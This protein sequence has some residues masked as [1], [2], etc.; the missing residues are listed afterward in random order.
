MTVQ[1]ANLHNKVKEQHIADL[2]HRST[3]IDKPPSSIKV[4]TSQSIKGGKG[5]YV[6]FQSNKDAERACDVL[7]GTKLKG[8]DI[9]IRCCDKTKTET[10]GKNKKK[11]KKT[12]REKEDDLVAAM[13][14]VSISPINLKK[15]KKTKQVKMKKKSGGNKGKNKLNGKK[16]KSKGFTAAKGAKKKK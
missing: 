9:W 10:G 13:M 7:N 16:K 2:L 3:V 4:T 8:K 5:C 14:K 1:L 11:K 12:K 15:I 6:V